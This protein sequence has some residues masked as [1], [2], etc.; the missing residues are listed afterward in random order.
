MKIIKKNF[1]FIITCLIFIVS[2]SLAIFDEVKEFNYETEILEQEQTKCVNNDFPFDQVPAER[3]ADYKA[4]IAE[5]CLNYSKLKHLKPSTINLFVNI[6]DNEHLTLLVYGTIFLVI[7]PSLLPICH[8]LKSKIIKFYCNRESYNTM[9]R[10]L[11]KKAYRYSW[12]VPLICL[13]IFII[14]YLVS[15]HFD[16]SYN[17]IFDNGLDDLC[18]KTSPFTFLITYLLNIYFYTLFLVN[19]GL[20]VA[21]K[22]QNILA[23]LIESFLIFIG[24][25]LLI[26]V[27]FNNL[28]STFIKVPF[29]HYDLL[30]YY[31][32]RGLNS[33]LTS[34]IFTGFLS[35][36][37]GLIAYLVYK[38]KEKLFIDCDKSPKEKENL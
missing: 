5:N 24:L 11:F 26:E 35:L 3:L 33:Y 25:D 27:A 16:N 10:K 22:N 29:Y 8:F 30:N 18:F 13:T 7:L 38:N 36:S 31:K 21:R 9:L 1:L 20:I 32:F 28:L 37:S 15:G 2:F 14:S 23:I 6:M 17:F 4:S 34:L 19:I 12:F